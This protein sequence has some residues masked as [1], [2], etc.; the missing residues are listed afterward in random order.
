AW[1]IYVRDRD[2]DADG[3]FDEAG[4]VATNRVSQSTS[5]GNPVGPDANLSFEP[6]ISDDG[7]FVAFES[8][9]TNLVTGDTN[10]A[11]DIFVRDR[12]ANTTARVSV[13]T[14]GVQG[15]AGADSRRARISADARFITFHSNA[16]NLVAG[17]AAGQSDIF[18]RDRD[19]DRDGL[20][21]EAGAVATR[22]LSLSTADVEANGHSFDS[23]MNA[24]GRYVAFFSHATNLIAVDVNAQPDIFLRDRDTDT[25]GI[26]DE[27]GAVSTVLLSLDS[28]GGQANDA[29]FVPALS[30]D[31][32][33]LTFYSKATDLVAGDTNLLFDVFVRDITGG[34]T[35]RVSVSEAGDEALGG[36]SWRA[37]TTSSFSAN[38]SLVAFHSFATNFVANDNNASLDVFV[39]ISDHD[40]DGILEPK[41]NCAAVSNEGQ[42]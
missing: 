5:G 8:T 27:A 34:Y 19:L 21:D 4:A 42:T 32:R 37:L 15:T 33:Y 17:D 1:D 20:Y 28:A 24:D 13:S 30:P 6:A 3:I 35:I 9:A 14:A 2:T 38:A 12:S 18:V 25:D 29:S 7:R 36:D 31:G 16:S 11:A 22:R 26:F 41:D 10:A 39:H 40:N 23:A